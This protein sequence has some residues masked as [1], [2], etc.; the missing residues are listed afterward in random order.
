MWQGF[1]VKIRTVKYV[2]LVK[3]RQMFNI[4]AGLTGVWMAKGENTLLKSPIQCY[5]SKFVITYKA[6]GVLDDIRVVL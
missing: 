1:S 4:H 5:E 3:Y 2:Y 6:E